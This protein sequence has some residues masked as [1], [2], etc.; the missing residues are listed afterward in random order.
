MIRRARLHSL[1]DNRE[2]TVER[3]GTIRSSGLSR[4]EGNREG[5]RVRHPLAVGGEIPADDGL[6]IRAWAEPALAGR[7]E[8]RSAKP[9]GS[10][11]GKVLALTA[12]GKGY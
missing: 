8:R 5:L 9:D 7:A 1:G 10:G 11:G 12:G 4:R 3:V 2:K 6:G